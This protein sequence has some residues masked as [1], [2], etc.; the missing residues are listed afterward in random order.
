LGVLGNSLGAA[1]AMAEARDDPRVEALALDSMHTRLQYQIEVRLKHADHPAYPG[2]WAIF[3]GIRKRT[4]VDVGSIDAADEIGAF[5]DR[6]IL[7][8]H[9]TADTED[10]PA[11]TQSFY[12]DALAEGVDIELHFCDGAG[13]NAPAGMP[14]TVCHDA[15]AAW[16]RDFF[17]R[18]LVDG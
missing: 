8:T 9:G 18:T 4:G 6:P 10:L 2:T 16:M 11:R 1:T 5:T 17:T 3:L 7:L 13:H 12:G 14:V 15:F